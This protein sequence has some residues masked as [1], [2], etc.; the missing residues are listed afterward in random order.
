MS[1]LGAV[2]NVMDAIGKA[3]SR[4]VVGQIATLKWDGI[5]ESKGGKDEVKRDTIEE[6]GIKSL[7]CFDKPVKSTSRQ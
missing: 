1:F 3:K 4:E 5:D 2:A 6:D 7:R